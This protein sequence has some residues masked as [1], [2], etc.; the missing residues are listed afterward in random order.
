MLCREGQ[1]EKLFHIICCFSKSWIFLILPEQI[2]VLSGMYGTKPQREAP[3]PKKK[4]LSS[5]F[6]S[7]EY[8][9]YHQNNF[10]YE[11][12]MRFVK[13][14]VYHLHLLQFTEEQPN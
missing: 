13:Y 8:S 5:V 3:P 10:Q 14:L 12:I 4:K 11:V 2:P 9:W 6:Q 7:R 1:K